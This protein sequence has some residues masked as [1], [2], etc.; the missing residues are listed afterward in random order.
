MVDTEQASVIAA[1]LANG[2]V[3]PLTGKRIFSSQTVRD[4]LSLMY[5]CGMYDYSGQFA[6]Q[7]GLPAKSG[8]AGLVMLVIP[9][10]AGIAIWSPRLDSYGNSTRGVEFCRLLSERFPIHVFDSVGGEPG[11][12]LNLLK[13]AP[14]KDTAA[15]DSYEMIFAAASGDL[16]KVI[17]MVNRN[18]SV[19]CSDYDGRTPLHLAVAEERLS[20]VEYLL[21][22]GANADF[23]DRWGQTPLGEAKEKGNKQ[24]L[25][26]LE[27]QKRS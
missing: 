8:V 13:P 26:A 19:N 3:N 27:K 20:V 2:G 23:K 24:I 9:D 25:E 4:C 14:S 11:E 6:F 15:S 17:A 10:V 1:T 22:H 5:S 7:I 21:S 18:V 16:P 12:R